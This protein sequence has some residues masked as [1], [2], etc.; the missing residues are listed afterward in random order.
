MDSK[1]LLVT[2]RIDAAKESIHRARFAFLL[3]VFSCLALLLADWNGYFSWY[4]FFI[5]NPRITDVDRRAAEFP[6]TAR[7][8]Y[9]ETA[10]EALIKSWIDSRIVAVAPLGLRFGVSDIGLVG[11]SGLLFVVGMLWYC[12]RRE[13]RA[14]VGLLRDIAEDTDETLKALVFHSIANHLVFHPVG[15]GSTPLTGLN[16]LQKGRSSRLIRYVNRF[17]GYLPV[18][19]SLLLLMVEVLDLYVMP[20]IFREV[21]RSIASTEKTLPEQFQFWAML[22]WPAISACLLAVACWDISRFSDASVRTLKEFER[23]L[24]LSGVQV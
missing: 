2:A 10:Q 23:L 22:W 19:T 11:P 6:S 18:L 1:Q 21:K 17:L 8:K 7:E 15:E 5:S 24:D 9:L 16:K 4:R 14:I 20:P 12:S 3:S 13:N